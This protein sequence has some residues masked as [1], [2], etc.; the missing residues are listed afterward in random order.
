MPIE[1]LDS[2][3]ISDESEKQTK[4][5]V[6]E[7]SDLPIWEQSRTFTNVGK[8]Y[9]R[10]DGPEK[11]T[12]RAR[13]SYDVR[14]PGQLYA[15]V[16]RCPHPHARLIHLDTTAAAQHP[17]VHAVLSAANV[18][19]TITFYEEESPL[20]SKTLRFIGDEVAAVA[21]ESEEI[22][23][24]AL[25][26]IVAEYEPLP[27]VV[28][29]QEAQAPDAPQV[30]KDGNEAVH[31]EYERGDVAAG[32]AEAHVVIDETYTTETALHNSFE[33][34]GC[35]AVWEGDRLT[36]YESTQ[37]IFEVRDQVAE[38][39]GIP[40][41]NVRVIKEYMGGGFGAKQILWKQSL[42]AALLARHTGHPVQL[43]LDREA[44]NLAAGNRNGTVQ[45]V[46]IGAKADGTLTAITVDVQQAV[47][48]Y[49]VGGEASNVL[50]I[51]QQLYRCPNVRATQKGIYINAGPSVAF[52]A[53][54]YVEG[55]FGLESAMDELARV[56]DMD[57]ITLRLRNYTK[58]DQEEE[59]PYSSPDVLRISYERVSAAFG[60]QDYTKP[61]IQ[62]SKRRGIGFA[63]HEWAAGS[64]SAPGYAWIKLNGDGSADV[65]TGAQD[66]GTGTRTALTQIAAE[67]LSLSMDRV[68]LYLGDTA[69]GPY[70]PTSAGSATLP[71]LAP[72]IREAAVNVKAQLFKAASQLLEE[73]PDN[74]V[75]EDGHIYVK[76][77]AQS[78]VSV[79]EICKAISPHMIQG[80]G[81]RTPNPADL[82]VRTFGAQCVEVEVDIETG[83]VSILRVAASHDCGR[84]VN[85]KM[86]ESQVIGGVTQGIGFALTEERVVDGKRG[87]VLNPNLEEY[88]I[89]TVK[90]IP[91]ILHAP[92]DQADTKANNSGIKGIG[93]PPI[94][95][96]APAIANA[97]YDA[98]GIRLRHTP[99][100]RRRLVA[101]L[102]QNQA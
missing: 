22:A 23:E 68:N 56:L 89:P 50:G 10:V 8:P 84:I 51:Y 3:R 76:G 74:L 27:F 77:D 35:T 45:H 59:K 80:H 70:A 15:A 97:I 100:T 99:I 17:G 46:R 49:M 21:A 90:D 96:T 33:P 26:L 94:I 85:P 71:T 39:L 19:E 11:V 4:L 86:V 83:E 6:E 25:Q 62:G 78:G 61:V 32:F 16:L 75:I 2:V 88:K 48:A 81:T 65:I 98:V 7:R 102:V 31:K 24:D 41:H 66:I 91:P 82:T 40:V 87:V 28:D 58:T 95:P 20:F 72:A 52:R 9:G 60:W 37:G 14:L 55:C 54:G 73:S 36:L 64:G 63:A 53:P 34:H 79:E 92:I 13:Y 38:K 67:E 43:M 93:E 18:P 69:R 47:G 1:Q 29:M 44:E 12:G 101:A 30:H 42:I 5:K 57:P